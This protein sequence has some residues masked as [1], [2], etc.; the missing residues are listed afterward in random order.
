LLNNNNNEAWAIDDIALSKSNTSVSWS[1]NPSGF[2]SSLLNPGNVTVTS[3]TVYT[4]TATNGAGCTSSDTAGVVINEVPANPAVAI[5]T[6]CG[7][8]T[9]NLSATPGTNQVIDWYNASSGGTLLASASNTYTTPSISTTT[10]Y[11]AQARNLTTGCVSARVAD[12]AKIN[13]IPSAPTNPINASRCG[14]GTV[15]ISATLGSGGNSI[16]WYAAS[17]GGSSI[18]T[19][20]SFTTPSLSSTTIY[21]AE[22][23]NTTTGCVS[24]TRTT[25]TATVVSQP[26]ASAGGSQTVCGAQAVT[27]SGASSSNGT[28]LW[29]E[30]GAGSITSGSTSLT[31]I[32][33]AV[34]GDN[35]N[36]ITLTMSVSNA[37]CVAATATYSILVNALPAT[38]TAVNNSVCQSGT[39]NLSTTPAE[40]AGFTYSWYNVSTGGTALSTGTS[41]TTPLISTTTVY[42]VE[43]K[44]NTT[45]CISSRIPVTATVNPNLPASVNITSNATNNT[46]CSGTSVIFTAT[47]INGGANPS[48]QWKVNGANAGTNSATFTT[49][50]LT[51]GQT[52]Q[53]VMTS[54]ATPCLTGSPANSNVINIT[55]NPLPVAPGAINATRCG[56]GTLVLGASTTGANKIDWY[57]T[58]T[59]G[60]LQFSNSNTFTTPSISTT[61]IYYA[62]TRDSVTGCLSSVRTAVTATV[63]PVTAVTCPG[64][65]GVCNNNVINITGLSPAGGT[66]TGVGISGTTFNPAVAGIGEQ[67][68]NYS[69]T[70][71][72]GC[73]SS[74]SFQIQVASS[75]PVVTAAPSYY[76]YSGTSTNINLSS[77]VVGTTYTW[78]VTSN[79]PDVIGYSSQTTPVAGPINQVLYNNGS[80]TADL[81]YTITPSLNG[82]C[83]GTPIYVVV[84]IP[85]STF[86]DDPGSFFP[87]SCI[88]NMGVTPQTV[89]NGLKPYGLVYELVNNYNIPVY[90]CIKP[91]KTYQSAVTK[92]DQEDFNLNGVS[93]KGGAFVIP[94]NFVSQVQNVIDN[95]VAQG[96]V[97]NYSNAVFSPPVYD[98]I[99][100]MPKVVLDANYGAILESGFYTKAGIPNTAYSLGGVPTNITGCDDIYALPHADPDLWSQLY[101]DSL[102]NFINTRGW[103]FS[104][105]K[106]VSGIESVPTM[107]FLSDS[108]LV[109]DT[110]H[111]NGTIP[112]NYSLKQGYE[113]TQIA[114]DPF[115]QFVGTIDGAIDYGLETIYLPVK[116]WRSTTKVAVYDSN[117]VNTRPNPTVAY[118]NKAGVVVYG[119]AFGDTSKG[120]VLYM[121]GHDFEH[122]TES[123]DVAAARTYGN[124][125]L[126]AGIGTRP[127]IVPVSIPSSAFSGQTIPLSVFLPATQSAIVSYQWFSDFGA[128]FS[129]Q[130]PNTNMTVPGVDVTTVGNLQF[131]VKDACGRTGLY[132]TSIIIY[133]TIVNNHI[134]TSQT[135]CASTRPDTL[136][137]TTPRTNS[138]NPISY[139]W[140]MSSTS[141][142]SGFTA[143]PGINN[144]NNYYPPPLSAGLYWFRREVSSDTITVVSSS[145][146]ITVKPSPSVTALATIGG[147]GYNTASICQ[148]QSLSLSSVGLNSSDTLGSLSLSNT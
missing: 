111:N 9:V 70:N 56:T 138:L 93:Y 141:S 86:C 116:G 3:S 104:S 40:P 88:I 147:V 78:T 98:L 60:T 45:G 4:M 47:P 44:N 22:S 80:S 143:A 27:V 38:P 41:Y 25:V 144:Q 42:Y 7:T 112:Y 65:I 17:S 135:I 132:C 97:V 107:R 105:C 59:A 50:T 87:G 127:K 95:W 139:R 12:T 15:N 140:L 5:G 146:Q 68:I 102:L 30:N 75:A 85:N 117:Y 92:V 2:S 29:T 21:Y 48:Y 145:I 71:I 11:Y 6:N 8:G 109:I 89:G 69:Y 106:A 120:M 84:T 125:I 66:L 55:V 39:V 96:V 118:P 31:P 134:A 128:V 58:A 20:T 130:S 101:K 90:W 94:S 129:A 124:F 63:N 28:I 114:S 33:T 26:T 122:G 54:N 35:G 36:T 136:I 18:G 79:S 19:G 13:A 14:T 126:R 43:S 148:G 53:V 123:E 23:V 10:I 61:S 133:P 1:S 57:S 73:T 49:S 99:T 76:V 32:Y 121:G 16:S 113:G 51:N 64:N 137:G 24:A 142:S 108:G 119:R 34:A 100:R 115:M 74:C 72:Q 62:Q 82:N 131:K 52:V 83:V 46:I 67:N 37:P 81:T 91:D 103:L 77:T 110:D